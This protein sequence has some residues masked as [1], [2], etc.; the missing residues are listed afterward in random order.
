MTNMTNHRPTRG[1]LNPWPGE[2]R[3]MELSRMLRQVLEYQRHYTSSS[4]PLM[5]ER[6]RLIK[7]ELPYALYRGLI[8]QQ[9]A[10][11]TGRLQVNPSTGSGR[12]A[13]IP[14]VQITDS[15]MSTTV[16]RGWY[17]VLLFAGDGSSVFAS[18]NKTSTEERRGTDGQYRFTPLPA[19]ATRTEREWALS[20]IEGIHIEVSQ[21]L[22]RN[23]INLRS[24]GTTG[25][26][27]ERT[28]VAGV[29]YARLDI[30]DDEV[31]LADLAQLTVLLSAVYNALPESGPPP[32][33][34]KENQ[35]WL[36][37]DPCEQHGF[38]WCANCK[39]IN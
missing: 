14:L 33:T 31:I 25:Q 38:P 34:P 26:A 3:S 2:T 18:L 9:L 37:G 7:R 29:Q 10:I 6:N 19:S 27:Y 23:R 20:Q 5:R 21:P 36:K 24:R 15:K 8:Q 22:L 17:L 1:P 30:P 32:P 12:N 39:S 16:R 35:G 13:E 11:P 4:T 28:H